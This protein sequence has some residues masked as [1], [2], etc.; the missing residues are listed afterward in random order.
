MRGF[1]LEPSRHLAREVKLRSEVEALRPG[2]L[3]LDL[4]KR[5]PLHEKALHRIDGSELV[6]PL[7]KRARISF[8]AEQLREKVFYVRR[9]GNEQIGFVSPR[10]RP[11]PAGNQTLM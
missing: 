8:D 2:I 4:V 3:R 1:V 10:N 7:G 6:V 11:L 5:S 9:K